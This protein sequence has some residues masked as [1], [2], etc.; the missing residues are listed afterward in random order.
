[1]NDDFEERFAQISATIDHRYVDGWHVS[2]AMAAFREYL[3]APDRFEPSRSGTEIGT[4][5]AA[6]GPG[7]IVAVESDATKQR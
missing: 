1:M 7:A 5:C 4:R 3:A 2:R 6:T